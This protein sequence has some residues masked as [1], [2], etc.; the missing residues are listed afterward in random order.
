MKKFLILLTLITLSSCTCS[1]GDAQLTVDSTVVAP[2]VLDTLLT[3]TLT[4]K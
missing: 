4:V 3:D 1:T 2:A